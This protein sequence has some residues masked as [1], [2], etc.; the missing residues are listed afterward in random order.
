MKQM[1]SVREDIKS[2]MTERT[3]DFEVAMLLGA[4][5]S[6]KQTSVVN[7]FPKYFV[8][9]GERRH[10][11]LT[12]AANKLP[13]A[14]SLFSNEQLPLEEDTNQLLKH[15]LEQSNVKE[16]PVNPSDYGAPELVPQVVFEVTE[17]CLGKVK[18]FSEISEN[19][20]VLKGYHGS[21]LSNWYCIS[22]GG[23]R[24]FSGTKRESHGSLFGE[25]IYLS[26]TLRLAC[27]FSSSAPSWKKCK[28]GSY[29]RVIAQCEWIATTETTT[30]S[31]TVASGS[32]SGA[33]VPEAYIVIPNA[34]HVRVHRLL[35]YTA[36]DSKTKAKWQFT[37]VWMIVFYA[38]LLF[39]IVMSQVENRA[40][41]KSL[42]RSV[43]LQT[44]FLTKYL[45]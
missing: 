35:V 4:L 27:D 15:I 45:Y 14:S 7:P 34:A 17:T 41:A 44:R 22:K 33:K 32:G 1:T 12:D 18:E 9:G 21:A 2:K 28:L 13:S 43:R 36:T 37:S 8:E 40:L 39:S 31:N 5:K 20:E 6:F 3:Y 29:L 42:W 11:R 25:G 10:Q 38:F 24:N 16:V 23:L 19:R 30:A 26:H